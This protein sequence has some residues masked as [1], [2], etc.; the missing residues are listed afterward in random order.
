MK[1]IYLEEE[2]FLDSDELRQH[3]KLTKQD[4]KRQRE[5]KIVE[6]MYVDGHFGG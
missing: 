1:K 4:R 5:R 3:K 2:D 6:Q